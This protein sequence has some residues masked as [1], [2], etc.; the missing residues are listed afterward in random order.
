MGSKGAKGIQT[1][2]PALSGSRCFLTCRNCPLPPGLL[3]TDPCKGASVR[4]AVVPHPCQALAFPIADAGDQVGVGCARP[5][6]QPLLAGGTAMVLRLGMGDQGGVQLL[7][8]CRT[9][10]A[11]CRV[12]VDEKDGGNSSCQAPRAAGKHQTLQ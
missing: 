6:A 12:A 10:V 2:N 7:F 4:S 11:A 3:Y 9:H 5:A 1:A 8:T